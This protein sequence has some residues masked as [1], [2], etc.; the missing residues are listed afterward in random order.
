[1]VAARGGQLA[2]LA[3]ANELLYASGAASERS[4]GRKGPMRILICGL[5]RFYQPTGICRHTVNL[6]NCLVG[7]PGVD[8]VRLVLGDW[9]EEYHRVHL[10]LDP[11][12]EVEV[13]HGANNSYWRNWWFAFG[14]PAAAKSFRADIVHLAFPIPL[15]QHYDA[16]VIASLHDLYP[17]DYPAN[18]K[19]LVRLY[20]KA[21][22]SECLSKADGVAAVSN[23]TLSSL[24]NH[25]PEMRGRNIRLVPN[26][27]VLAQSP[28]R[29]D[30][31]EG[32]GRFLLCVAQHEANKQLDLAMQA[33]A[34]LIE[35]STGSRKMSLVIV[36]SGGSQSA[37]LEK[38]AAEL[39][40][41]DRICWAPPLCDSEL[42][43]LYEHCDLFLS[44]SAVEGFCLPVA[45]ALACGA[46]VACTDI[47]THR[48]V[49]GNDPEYFLPIADPAEIAALLRCVLSNPKPEPRRR[50]TADRTSRAALDL[51]ARALQQPR[52][53]DRRA[54]RSR[55]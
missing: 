28:S 54:A 11:R 36:G 27:P 49:A 6:A 47:P 48:E 53:R 12:V 38:L 43:W 18:N 5:S 2:E 23:T 46:R 26:Y 8:A 9:Q 24:Y 40:L 10:S 52:L 55:A 20:K 33:F 4:G 29:P 19:S 39:G 14:L 44:T 37:M 32:K 7:L 42:R 17:Y 31:M 15:V 30:W 51:Y 21:V 34:Q 3:Q 50:F 35:G 1:M 45:E 13:A 25:F 41:G 22:M 16:A